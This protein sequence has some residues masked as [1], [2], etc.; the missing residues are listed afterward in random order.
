[1]PPKRG[2]PAGRRGTPRAASRA[3]GTPGPSGLDGSR[4]SQSPAPPSSEAR[5][6]V[7]RTPG[8]AKYSTSYG[9]PS[10]LT[11]LRRVN[12]G[13]AIGS[14][15]NALNE[16]QDADEE[17]HQ[18]HTTRLAAEARSKGE[19][20]PRQAPARKPPAVEE[21]DS[22]DDGVDGADQ[23]SQAMPPPPPPA[24]RTRQTQRSTAGAAN[25]QGA[26]QGSRAASVQ[27]GKPAA[28]TGS[29]AFR[30]GSEPLHSD[31]LS[32]R[33]FIEESEIYGSADVATP[34]GPQAQPVKAPDA[35]KPPPQPFHPSA[36]ATVAD[37]EGS[38]PPTPT[39]PATRENQQSPSNI[40][41][42]IDEDDSEDP[43]LNP[44][45][46]GVRTIRRLPTIS[47][48]PP[49]QQPDL[50]ARIQGIDEYVPKNRSRGPPSN[51]SGTSDEDVIQ[52]SGIFVNRAQ[53]GLGAK[54]Q[55]R[56]PNP[57]Q[58]ARSGDLLLPRPDRAGSETRAE[59]GFAAGGSATG[60]R[61]PGTTDQSVFNRFRSPSPVASSAGGTGQSSQQSTLIGSTRPGGSF[62]GPEGGSNAAP[63][64]NSRIPATSGQPA[65][66]RFRSP[67]PDASS[68]DG[69]VPSPQQNNTTG[70]GRPGGSPPRAMGDATAGTSTGSQVPAT[71]GRS[72]LLRN[73]F[74]RRRHDPVPDGDS[75]QAPQEVDNGNRQ[76]QRPDNDRSK[77]AVPAV[78]E[79]PASAAPA[80]AK[81][82][83]GAAGPDAAA[84]NTTGPDAADP[85]VDRDESLRTR[86][87]KWF[88]WIIHLRNWPT[89]L[90]KALEFY[91]LLVLLCW[92]FLIMLEICL[93]TKRW[94][95]I[96]VGKDYQYYGMSLEN[97]RQNILQ[98]VPWIVLHPFAVLTGNLDYADFRDQLSRMEFKEHSSA[99]RMNSIAAATNQMRRILPELIKINVGERR[100][101]WAIDDWFWHVLNEE[102][103]QGSFVWSLLTVTK[104]ENGSYTISDTHWDAIRQRIQNERLLIADR[105]AP[106]DTSVALSNEVMSY[107]ELSVSQ[108]FR[109]WLVQ[110]EKDVRRVTGKNEGVP[111]AT[112]KD[113]YGDVEKI[114]AERLKELG[115]QEGVVTKD[116]FIEKME[117][118]FDQ[119][120][121]YIKTEMEHLQEKL[122]QALGIAIDAKNSVDTP[123]GLT[124]FEV[125]ELVDESVRRAIGDA[126]LEAMAKGSIKSHLNELNQRKNYF[127]AL[128]G[129]VVDPRLTSDT[130]DWRTEQ[131]VRQETGTWSIWGSGKKKQPV[132]RKG[133]KFSGMPF[134]PSFALDKWEEDGEC[135]CAGHG[136]AK[137]TNRIA[138]LSIFTTEPVIPQHL[139]VEHIGRGATFDP[140]AMPRDIEFWMQPPPDKRARTLQDWSRKKWADAWQGGGPGARLVQK[141]FLKVGEFRFDSAVGK[142]ES[143]VFKLSDEL[144]GMDAQTRQVLVRAKSNYGAEDHTCFYRLRLFG[145]EGRDAWV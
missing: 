92:G 95:G 141:G 91:G 62:P 86:A 64:T 137:R 15:G 56:W 115:L 28:D 3:R 24:P 125:A 20:A 107:V 109:D 76:Q 39:R 57:L 70:C 100:G 133:S 69:T 27:P 74:A 142:G 83:P 41:D 51:T 114:I 65:P 93:P 99:I 30:L 87:L 140:E 138:D 14:I 80:P 97:W 102:M 144:L 1:M 58:D 4:E 67:S 49:P 122:E 108:A 40:S 68:D 21:D 139:V 26:T 50:T 29:N 110:N 34:R 38:A 5:V 78:P 131:V 81:T 66:V 134:A 44:T 53:S 77:G 123:A 135:W 113:L 61:V 104:S 89:K 106:G 12:T 101:D 117:H 9:S 98:F 42:S 85:G 79:V 35:L 111:S 11:A 45:P 25:I 16:L 118:E 10:T 120:E 37:R 82:A 119:R 2:R 72:S 19:P 112:Y 31:A 129:A 143:Q 33:S 60:S 52:A 43:L 145:E 73:P 6:R 96:Q 132:Y 88:R 105:P 103:T 46:R 126:Q 94:E 7:Q 48:S 55:P 71:L 32:Q 75:N 90:R 36:A 63:A 59:G 23:A 127:S 136:D 128:R 116:M 121:A 124:R 13:S 17:D 84:S 22:D 8:P 47:Q 54:R 130:Y 18:N